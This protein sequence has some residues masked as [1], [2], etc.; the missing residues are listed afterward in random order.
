MDNAKHG[1]QSAGQVRRLKVPVFDDERG[2]V[3]PIEHAHPDLPFVPA[4][5]FVICDVPPG[6]SR[7][8]H[9]LTC[10]QLL[11]AASGSVKVIARTGGREA[12]HALDTPGAALFIPEG[13]WIAL[14]DFSPGA[15]LVVFAAKPYR[16]R[17]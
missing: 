13:T 7:A 17:D 6:K 9:T 16:R 4:R 14:R 1:A 12:S 3:V 15:V 11:V 2:R 5:T 10:D 8:E